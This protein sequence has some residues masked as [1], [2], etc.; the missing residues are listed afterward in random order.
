MTPPVVSC[1]VPCFNGERYL[2]EALRSI[3]AQTYRPLEIIVVD[4]G[5]T[6]G[7]ADVVRGFG[8]DVRYHRQ[9]NRGPA[10]ACNTGVALATGAYVAFLE[11]DD[12]WMPEKTQRQLIAFEANPALEYCV[13]HIRNFWARGLEQEARRYRDLAVMQPVAGYVVQTLIARREAFDRAGCFDETL[14]FAFAGDWFLRAAESGSV[15]SLIPDVLTR[16]RLHEGNYSRVHRAESRD[17][18][19]H[20]VKA[21]LDR[22]RGRVPC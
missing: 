16:R 3:L 21:A 7:S 4:D 20:V 10:G 13:T 11:Q 8:A 2:G 12:L 1:I 22:R 17:Q 18:F 19:L 9:A 14:R 6:D 15:G 5:S